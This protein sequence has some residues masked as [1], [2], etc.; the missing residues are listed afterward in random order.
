MESRALSEWVF[1]LKLNSWSKNFNVSVVESVVVLVNHFK[2]CCGR[3]IRAQQI[4]RP[5]PD[6]FLWSE[7]IDFRTL[8]D[9]Q[10]P[11]WNLIGRDKSS[12]CEGP[13]KSSRGSVAFCECSGWDRDPRT[14]DGFRSTHILLN[15][16]FLAQV[17]DGRY[18]WSSI[19]DAVVNAVWHSW[20]TPSTRC[21]CDLQIENQTNQTSE[22]PKNIHLLLWNA[23]CSLL[24]QGSNNRISLKRFLSSQIL[25]EKNLKIELQNLKFSLS[26]QLIV[27]QSLVI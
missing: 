20:I 1:F 12:H 18:L 3:K 17:C 7:R 4:Y 10:Q 26:L 21:D 22:L 13:F 25:Y 8:F 24:H 6:N 11:N 16:K 14:A 27:V 23:T 15:E 19:A 5:S 9:Q 2:V